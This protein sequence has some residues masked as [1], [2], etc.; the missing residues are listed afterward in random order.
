MTRGGRCASR[1]REESSTSPART[2]GSQLSSYSPKGRANSG[3][4]AGA[5][6]WSPGR[7]TF[8]EYQ[9]ELYTQGRHGDSPQYPIALADLEEKAS[10]MMTPKTWGYVAG[11]S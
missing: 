9:D 6:R 2:V 5:S 4:V 3:S 11:G 7:M 1:R 8:A 10:H